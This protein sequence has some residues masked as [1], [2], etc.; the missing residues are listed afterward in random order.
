LHNCAEANEHHEQLEQIGEPS[1]G[2]ELVD[3]PKAD[4]ADDD[5]N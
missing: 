2:G 5:D 4:C 1:V 3:G